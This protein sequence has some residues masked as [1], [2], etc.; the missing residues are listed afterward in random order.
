MADKPLIAATDFN[1]IQDRISKILG[2]GVGSR[3]YGQNYESTPVSQ[4]QEIVSEQWINLRSDIVTAKYHQDGN[5]PTLVAAVKG[6]PIGRD[7]GDPVIDYAAMS[8]QADDNRFALGQGQFTISPV[9]SRTYTSAWTGSLTTNLVVQFSNNNDARYFFN[10]GGKLR[11]TASRSGGS[12]TAQNTAWTNLL[13]AAGTQQ[14]GANV[15]SV[16]NFYSLEG[17]TSSS[18]KPVYEYTAS[19]PYSANIYRITAWCN[20]PNN[21]TGLANEVTLRITLIDG[22]NDPGNNPT[23]NPNTTGIVDGTITITVDKVTATLNNPSITGPSATS[24]SVIS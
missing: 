20:V 15:P 5:T 18:A 1:T 4:G 8:S 6:N 24:L 9:A 11:I 19:T 17:T 10:S 12:T 14:F 2:T 3:G 16:T 21:S 23:D 7:A 22:Y 13:N